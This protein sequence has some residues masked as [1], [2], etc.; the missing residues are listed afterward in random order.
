ARARAQA[1]GGGAGRGGRRQDARR[2]ADRDADPHVHA[3]A[4]AIQAV[5][6]TTETL[7]REPTKG[8]EIAALEAKRNVNQVRADGALLG[9]RRAAIARLVMIALFGLV[10]TLRGGP[11]NWY[12]LGVG[13]AY[14]L[15][16]LTVLIAVHR[17]RQAK[18]EKARCV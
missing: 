3:Q 15:W 12:Q 18:P 13:S 8:T 1:H 6:D 4:Q 11:R 9:E 17:V 2:A 16:S 7:R 10:S 14:S 5:G